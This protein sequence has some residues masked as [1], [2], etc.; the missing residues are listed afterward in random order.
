M[1]S[2]FQIFTYYNEVNVDFSVGN[3]NTPSTIEKKKHIN[4]I[5]RYEKSKITCCINRL[6]TFG[7][8]NLCQYTDN[9]FF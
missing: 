1:K 3:N 8:Y 6:L 2:T 5:Y 7:R 4:T 9:L